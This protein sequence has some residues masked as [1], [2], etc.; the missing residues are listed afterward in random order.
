MLLKEPSLTS[1]EEPL[2]AAVLHELIHQQAVRAVRAAA[3]K[4]HQVGVLQLAQVG[5][6]RLQG[7]DA[8]EKTPNVI[9]FAAASPNSI[10]A[11]LARG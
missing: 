3:N 7:W 8:E 1:E 10:K 11:F 9:S 4:A 2:E 6:F 5:H